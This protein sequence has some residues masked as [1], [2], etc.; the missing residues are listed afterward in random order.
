MSRTTR[1]NLLTVL[2]VVADVIGLAAGWLA[3]WKVREIL[4]P[5][6]RDPINEIE[7]YVSALK[8]LLPLWLCICGFHGHYAHRERISSLNEVTR[9]L[10]STMGMWLATFVVSTLLRGLSMGRTVV[11]ASVVLQFFYLYTSRTVVR[12]LKRRA[13][14]RGKGLRRVLIVGTGETA[15]RALLRIVDHPEIGYEL[16]GLVGQPGEQ[17]PKAVNRVAFLGSIDHLDALIREHRIEE[18]FLADPKLPDDDKL[19]LVARCDATGVSF[20]IV[21]QM[22]EVTNPLIRIDVLDDLPVIPLQSGGLGPVRSAIKRVMDIVIGSILLIAFLPA[23]I[24]IAIWIRLDSPGPALFVHDRIGLRGRR[25][26]LWKFRTMAVDTKPYDPAPTDPNDPRI[27]RVGRWL[28]RTSLDELPQL[29][30]VA[31]GD[32]SMVGPRPEMPQIVERYEPWQRIRLGVKP[33]ITG[34]W[35]IIGRKNLPLELNL[36]YDLYYIKNQSLILDLVILLKTIPAVVFGRGA[37]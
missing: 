4:N 21:S 16:I 11:L 15:R 8:W 10:R 33:G 37:Y 29:C 17:P 32:M 6:F 31:R 28:R 34:L 5:Y 1:T 3:T 26:R 2:L 27:T 19:N 30:N 25:F 22:F 20:K 36:E 18:I 23:A 13:T 12:A 14:R 9:I 7:P 35:Q 24:V